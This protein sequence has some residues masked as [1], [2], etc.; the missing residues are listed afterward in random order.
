ML[1]DVVRDAIMF[2]LSGL[3]IGHSPDATMN[4]TEENGAQKLKNVQFNTSPKRKRRRMC[5]DAY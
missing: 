3:E 2:E 4:L 1:K 5:S